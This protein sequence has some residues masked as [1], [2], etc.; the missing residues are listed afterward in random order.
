MA[1]PYRAGEKK[2]QNRGTKRPGLCYKPGPLSQACPITW[3]FPLV[4]HPVYSASAGAPSPRESTQTPFLD[5]AILRILWQAVEWV[6]RTPCVHSKAREVFLE[7][8]GHP[9]SAWPVQ[10]SLWAA[11][12]LPTLSLRTERMR[13]VEGRG[14][15]QRNFSDP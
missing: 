7:P 13:K 15:E 4:W 12:S 2:E 11:D 3:V 10:C 9:P 6:E 5:R 1:C 14:D 8:P